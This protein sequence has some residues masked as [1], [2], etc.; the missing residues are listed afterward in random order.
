MKSRAYKFGGKIFRYDFDDAQVELIYKADKEMIQDNK[1]WIEKYGRP[2]WDIDEHGYTVAD[3]VGLGS[4]NWKNKE[5]RDEYLA[6]WID[7]LDEE[8]RILAEQYLAWG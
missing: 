1:E 6:G 3:T 4:N 8:S 7:E 5:A 2:L